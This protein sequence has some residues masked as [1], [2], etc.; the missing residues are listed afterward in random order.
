MR[1][2]KK[3]DGHSRRRKTISNLRNAFVI[4][5][6]IRTRSTFLF[7]VVVLFIFTSCHE[8]TKGQDRP[9]SKAKPHVVDSLNKPKINIRVN[10]HYDDK[11]NITGFDSTY[12]S[13]YSNIGHDTIAMDTLINRFDNYFRKSHSLLF[14]RQFNN[15]FFQDS[16]LYPD[17]FHKDFFQKRYELNTPYLRDM[18]QRMDSVKNSFYR[19]QAGKG[20]ATH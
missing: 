12:S 1:T 6:R 18:M 16:L 10:R 17:F 3:K 4:V 11:G 13:Y 20:K 15:L 2:I 9:L 14:D 19:D 5:D 7:T 8:K